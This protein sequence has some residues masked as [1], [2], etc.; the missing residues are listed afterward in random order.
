MTDCL[1]L[2]SCKHQRESS[3]TLNHW[4]KQ[5]RGLKNCKLSMRN[6]THE[7][8]AISGD[9]GQQSKNAYLLVILSSC[10]SCSNRSRLLQSSQPDWTSQST[11]FYRQSP[12]PKLRVQSLKVIH[13]QGHGALIRRSGGSLTKPLSRPVCRCS[14]IEIIGSSPC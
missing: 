1:T 11:L 2:D 9:F 14:W 7:T 4:D 3:C 12:R 6:F 8:R 10:G 13:P 5:P